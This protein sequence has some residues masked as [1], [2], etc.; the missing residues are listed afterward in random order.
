MRRVR[1]SWKFT[2]IIPPGSFRTIACFR[3]VI[4]RLSTVS[5]QETNQLFSKCIIALARERYLRFTSC[6]ASS[7]IMPSSSLYARR[8]NV[9]RM[10][11]KSE[12]DQLMA[13][14]TGGWLRVTGGTA[15]CASKMS[16]VVSISRLNCSRMSLNLS[17]IC[18]LMAPSLLMLLKFC[19]SSKAPSALRSFLK[20]LSMKARVSR[21]IDSLSVVNL[22]FTPC[23]CIVNFFSNAS[24][25][26]FSM[27]S[28][29]CCTRR[30]TASM[31]WESPVTALSS[32]PRNLW[33]S[34]TTSTI[35]RRS[36]QMPAM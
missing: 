36:L 28:T 16:R 3:C 32:G 29:I 27:G 11:W 9:L 2:T 20:E 14:A 26:R 10:R 18:R 24:N 35:C 6:P 12:R 4:A 34:S 7:C 25:C 13:P 1:S 19:S 31:P 21:S 5:A 22:A 17:I 33:K 30:M 15:L 8:L 23:H